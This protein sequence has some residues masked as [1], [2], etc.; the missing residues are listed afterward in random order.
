MNY[1]VD[2]LINVFIIKTV[3]THHNALDDSHEDKLFL[4]MHAKHQRSFGDVENDN[5]IVCR[6]C[7]II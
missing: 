1:D 7:D 2:N 5:D 3:K 6:L 4:E